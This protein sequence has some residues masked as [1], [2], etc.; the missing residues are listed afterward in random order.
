MLQEFI[1]NLYV[2]KNLSK[3]HLKGI[4]KIVKEYQKFMD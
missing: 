3:W 4:L 2:E 1:N